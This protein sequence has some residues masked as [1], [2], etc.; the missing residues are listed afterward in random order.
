MKCRRSTTPHCLLIAVALATLIGLAGCD[1]GG[2]NAPSYILITESDP[3]DGGTVTRSQPGEKYEAGTEVELTAEPGDGWT[4]DGWEGD[5]P[6]DAGRTVTITMNQ[7]KTARALFKFEGAGEPLP[8]DRVRLNGKEIFSNG[9]NVAWIN[10]ARDIGPTNTELGTFESIFEEV[11]N[12]GG[13][14][15]RLWLHTNGESTPAWNGSTVT[16]PGEGTIE[17]LRDILDLAQ[18]YDVGLELTLWSFDLLQEGQVGDN[19]SRNRQFLTTPDLIQSY[20]DNALTPMVEELGDHPALLSW[21][22]CNE[23]EGMT[24]QY[25]WTNAR[26]TMSDV[27]RFVNMTAGAIHRADPN[28]LVTNG[29]WSF[30]ALSDGEP[31]PAAKADEPAPLT[32]AELTEA[33]RVLSRKFRSDVSRAEAQRFVQQLRSDT[34]R[35]Y[36][37]DQR[38][39]DAGGDPK[40]TLDYYNVHYYEWAGTDLSPFHHDK[41]RWGL[42]EKPVVVGEF[43]M[44]TGD[45]DEKNDAIYDVSYEDLYTTLYDRGYA[46]ALGWQ[47]FDHGR[48][49]GELSVNW[50]RM[51]EN[52]QTMQSEH[53]G[54]VNV[55]L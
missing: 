52:M 23:P 5:V 29:T 30:I 33:Q 41:S 7:D 11:Q 48:R 21:E 28:A 47:W 2:A 32:E 35:N 16:G 1:S 27:Q 31:M 8:P 20:I 50:P 10:F 4:F 36:Y 12:N 39:I 45:D 6:S 18:Q 40:G 9:G 54:D 42:D 14:T 26:V 46:G 22:I 51:L 34:D 3:A 37:T 17:D 53:P 38:L 19:L 55:S 13:N 25:G 24:E 15:M 49:D 43:F 44:G